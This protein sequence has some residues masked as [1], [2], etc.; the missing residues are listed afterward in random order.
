MSIQTKPRDNPK[1][2]QTELDNFKDEEELENE[3]DDSES[4]VMRKS[5]KESW[6]DF[7]KKVEKKI[8]EILNNEKM[9][10]IIE[11]IKKKIDKLPKVCI[12]DMDISVMH[13][14]LN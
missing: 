5:T 13:I 9:K 1:S 11:A 2:T 6:A 12:N 4:A 14:H 8:K 3:K 7:K 10:E